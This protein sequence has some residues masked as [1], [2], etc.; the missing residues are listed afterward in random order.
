MKEFRVYDDAY[1]EEVFEA[2]DWEEALENAED[3]VRGGEWPDEGC[4]V[5]VTVESEGVYKRINVGIEPNHRKLIRQADPFNECCGHD[6]DDHEW[7]CAGEGG[8]KENPGVWAVS[9]TGIVVNSHC[10]WCG[11]HRT[12]YFP[13]SQRNPDEGYLTVEYQMPDDEEIMRLTAMG[14]MD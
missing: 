6:P 8:C 5:P 11:L 1:C 13:G 7:V 3:W 9:G 12:E 2:D 10:Y 14:A 4:V